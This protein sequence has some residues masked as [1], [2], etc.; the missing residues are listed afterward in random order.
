MHVRD[1]AAKASLENFILLIMVID[2]IQQLIA[3]RL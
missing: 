2:I 1:V 3:V